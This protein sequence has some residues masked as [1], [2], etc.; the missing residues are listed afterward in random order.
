MK[1]AIRTATAFAFAS[2]CLCSGAGAK[3]VTFELPDYAT[4]LFLTGMN[5]KGAVIGFVGDGRTGAQ[6]GFVWQPGVGL[7]TFFVPDPHTIKRSPG[8]LVF[9]SA[10]SADGV[11]TG[12]YGQVWPFGGGFVRAADGSI[13]TFSVGQ[14]TSA[15]GANRKGWVV[16]SYFVSARDPYQPYLRD[17]SGAAMEFSVPHAKGGAIATVVNRSRT[18]AGYAYVSGGARG[19]FRPA[20]GT[21]TLFGGTH[22]Y[23]YVTGMNDAG[24][25]AG[26]FDDGHPVA[27]VRTSDGTLTTFTGPNGAT[28][29]NAYAINNAGTVV[30]TYV[31]SSRNVHGFFRTADGTV[32][33]FDLKGSDGTDIRAINDKGAIA[34][35][36]W[37]GGHV[38][39][40]AGKP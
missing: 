5:D 13:T 37:V 22:H 24:T 40:F 39:G 25:I 9:P 19:F 10:I 28:D 3:I 30:G 12:S 36:T 6:P 35:K 38:Y 31:D 1:H 2:L 17:P 20:H 21:A 7:K 32:T 8:E 18:I 34:G 11:I 23:V 15:N 33:P 14:S 26:S 16:G 4:G 29:T 27:F